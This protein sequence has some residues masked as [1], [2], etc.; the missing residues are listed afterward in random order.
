M[1]ISI[2]ELYEEMDA[3][4]VCIKNQANKAIIVENCFWTASDYWGKLKNIVDHSFFE[5][6]GKE[7][8]FFRN[9]KPKFTSH[10]QF[11]TIL[12]EVLMFVPEDPED[13]FEFWND[14]LKRSKRFFEKHQEFVTYYETKCMHM[15]SVYFKRVNQDWV[16]MQQP[17]FYDA[18]KKFCSSHDHLVRGILA[19]KM[20]HEYVRERLR[21]LGYN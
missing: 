21:E 7:I 14:E 10:I 13:Q 3:A 18:D 9:I 5:C 11:Y 8:N 12:A 2:D 17:A 20:H 15:D 19:H 16:P 6:E 4:I 1:R